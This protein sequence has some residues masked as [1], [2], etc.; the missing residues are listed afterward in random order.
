MAA[1]S[2]TGSGVS[3]RR[4]VTAWLAAILLVTMLSNGIA[5]LAGQWTVSSFDTLLAD[6]AACYTV[7]NAL[8][9]EARAF[10]SYVREPSYESEQA[11]TSACSAAEQS[12][13]ALPF[14]YARIGED[15]YARTWN[16]LQGYEGYRQER[17]AFLRLSPSADTYIERMYHVMALQDY[18]AEYALRLTQATLE[19]ENTLYSSTAAHIRH[20]PWLYL[21]LFLTAAALMLLLIRVLRR[22][23]IL[24]L[25]GLAQ[26]SR[27]IA[28][29]HLSGPDLPVKSGD[30]VGQ[31]VGTFNRMKHAM[32][33]QL[34]T[35]QALHREEMHSLALEKDLEHTRLEVL[36]S[37]VNPHFLF[38]TLNMISCMAR[39][40]DASTTDQMIVH[41][42]SLFRHNLRTKRQQITLEEELD[43]L[44]D[45]I[46][47]QQMR[48]DGRITVEKSIRVQPAQVLVPSFMLQPVVE[49]AYS[50]GLKSCEEGGRILLR[51]WMEG[52]V[53]VLTVADNGKGMTAEELDALQARIAR[54][55]QTGRSIGLGNISRRIG[56]LYP[57]GRMQVYS[58]AGRGTVVRFELPQDE[59]AETQEEGLL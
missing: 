50:H 58:R 27:S 48:F 23:V 54:S 28:E 10:E 6:N 34:T 32:A 14:D 15:R 29:G 3:L 42:G 31:L 18:L 53:L 21:G 37:Q 9:D 7:Q 1:E 40:E 39:L 35:Q 22:A 19:Q 26:A 46:Y 52:K 43:G 44:E 45:Y 47:L 13:A 33:Q 20:L 36:K 17:D 57:G 49:N 55:E 8:Q 16:L 41:L 2:K 25:L 56:M 38:N 24:P 51:A 30:E 11:Y 12:L 59:Q 5:T 4:R